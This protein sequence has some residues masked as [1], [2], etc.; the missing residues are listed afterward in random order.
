MKYPLLIAMLI[1]LLPGAGPGRA[2]PEATQETTD[3]YELLLVKSPQPGA[4]FDRVVEWYSTQGGGLEL[5]QKRW[6]DAAA[7]DAAQ[8][9]QY[10]ILQGLLAERLRRT[11]KARALYGEAL[12]GGGDVAGAARLLAALET[13]EGNFPA[14]AEA[15]NMALAAET[16]PPMDRLDVMRSLALMYQRSFEDGKALAVWRQAME[17]FPDDPYVLEEAGEAFLAAEEYQ[18]ARETFTRLRD[19]SKKDPF[20]RIAASLRLARTADLEGRKDDAVHIYDL[21]LEETSEGSWINREIRGRIE[22]IYRRKDD[23]PGLLAYY[24]KRTVA[25]PQDYQSLVAQAQVLD[26]LGRDGEATERY[27]AAIKLAP[28]DVGLRLA[29]IGRLGSGGQEGEAMAEA[30]ELAKPADAPVE[31]LEMAGNLAWKQ[32]ETAKN[33]KSRELALAYWQRIAPAEGRDTAR[34]AR[35]AE[36]LSSHGETDAAV[37]Q[38]QRLLAVA[39]DATDARQRLAEVYQK[40]GDKAAALAVLEAMAGGG[41]SQPEN[42]LALARIEQRLEWKDEARATLKQARQLF[43]GNYDILNLSWNQ[44]LEDGDAA[45]AAELFSPVLESAPNAFFAGDVVKKYA[46]FLDRDGKGKEQAARLAESLTRAVDAEVLLRLALAQQ[47]RELAEKAVVFLKGQPNALQAAQAGAE[48]AQVFGTTEE[49][50][51]ALQAVAAADPR[52]AGDSLRAMARIQ[53]EAGETD[54]ALQTISQL[55]E[56]TPVDGS[57]YTLYADVASRD[58]RNDAAIARLR[59]GSRFVK[60]ATSLRLQLASLLQGQGRM[61]EAARTLQEAFEKED[62]DT[63]RKDIFRQQ[64]ACAMAMGRLDDLVASLREKQ[65]KEQGGARY[66]AYL[67]E[68]FILQNDFLAAGEELSRSLGRNPDN[69]DAV[70]RLLD[71]ADRGGD[72]QEGLRLAKRLVEIEPN[73]ENRASYLAR[74]FRAGEVD[75]GRAEFATVRAEIVK[76]PEGWDEVLSAMQD[77]GLKAETAAVAEEMAGQPGAGAA[78]QVQLAR[79]R[80]MQRDLKGA[81]AR[82]WQVVDVEDFGKG[83]GQALAAQPATPVYPGQ[84]AVWQRWKPVS[85]IANSTRNDLQQY[86]QPYYRGRMS[87][88]AMMS[89]AYWPGG[90][91]AMSGA[92]L[93]PD[94]RARLEAYFLLAMIAQAEGRGDDFSRRM[95]E[96]FA[97]AGVPGEIQISLLST[98]QNQDG[99]K[100]LILRQAENGEGDIEADRVILSF[101]GQW[102]D[103]DINAAMDRISDRVAK[104]NPRDVLQY[105]YGKLAKELAELYQGGKEND[106]K[107]QAEARERIRRFTESPGFAED[108]TLRLQIA[109]NAVRAGDM[110]LADKLLAETGAAGDGTAQA[111][112]W[113][114]QVRNVRMQI[115]LQ[116][117]AAN[118]PKAE[119]DLEKLLADMA[120]SPAPGMVMFSRGMAFY[121]MSYGMGRHGGGGMLAQQNSELVVGDSEFPVAVFSGLWQMATASQ[122]D[123]VE[124]WFAARAKPEMSRD[125]VGA[126]YAEWFNNGR[127]RALKRLE[128]VHGKAPTPRS[129]ALLL[130]AC[131]RMSKQAEALGVIDLAEM[132]ANETVSVRKLRKLRLLREAGRAEEARKLAEEMMKG[133]VPSDIRDPLI[134]ELSQLGIPATKLQAGRMMYRS[135]NTMDREN[136]IRQQVSKL[137]NEKKTDEAERIALHI[138]Q[139][140]LPRGEDYAQVSLR[141]S[142]V[143]S[144]SSMKRL[145]VLQEPLRER[146]VKDPADADAA[147][148]LAESSRSGDFTPELDNMVKIVAANPERVSQIS[149]ALALLSDRGE[150]RDRGMEL[151]CEILRTNPGVLVSSGMDL[152]QQVGNRSN[153]PEAAAL[154]A[155]TVAG[156][157][158]E[159]YAMV[160]LPARLGGYTSELPMIGQLAE[161]AMQAGKPAQAVALLKRALKGSFLGVQMQMEMYVPAV[162][163]LAEL[164]LAKGD[165]EGAAET[166]KG[167]LDVPANARRGGLAMAIVNLLGNYNPG[168]TG[169]DQLNRMA[170]LA[171]KTGTLETM[172]KALDEEQKGAPGVSASLLLRTTLGRPEV[173]KEWRR[174]AKSDNAQFQSVSLPLFGAIIRMLADQDDADVLIPAILDKLPAQQVFYGGDYSLGYLAAALPVLAKYRENPAVRKHVELILNQSMQGPNLQYLPHSQNYMMCLNALLDQGYVAEAKKLYDATASGRAARNFGN[175]QYFQQIEVR[176]NAAEKKAGDISVVCAAMESGPEKM[177]VAWRMGWAT[178]REDDNDRGAAATWSEMREE[179]PESVHPVEMEILAG[180]NP[181]A[182]EKIATVSKPDVSGSVEGRAPA[183]LGMLQA[184]WK[185]RQGEV[186]W[187]PLTAY[188]MGGNLVVKNG[189]PMPDGKP[190]AGF[191]ANLPGPLGKGTASGFKLLSMQ[192]QYTLPLAA[193]R[194]ADGDANALVVAGW[195]RG[196]QNGATPPMLQIRGERKGAQAY[197][198]TLY[199]RQMSG[200]WRQTVGVWT[201]NKQQSPYWNLGDNVESLE[202]SLLFQAYNGYNMQMLIEGQWASLQVVKLKLPDNEETA[203]SLLSKARMAMQKAG[204]VKEKYS[205]AADIYLQALRN[206]PEY[207]LNQWSSMLETFQKAGRMPELFTVLSNPALYLANPLRNYQRTVQNDSLI[208]AMVKA[209]TLPDAPEAAKVWL[210]GVRSAPLSDNQRYLIEACLLREKAKNDPGSVTAKDVLRVMGYGEGDAVDRER[211]S[212]L[213]NWSQES[214]AGQSLLELVT[215]RQWEPELAAQLKGMHPPIESVFSHNMLQAWVLAPLDPAAALEAWKR[216]AALRQSGQSY[217]Y[218]NDNV[219]EALFARLAGSHPSPGDLVAAARV[220]LADG[221]N[222]DYQQRRLADMLYAASKDKGPRSGEYAALW[223]DQEIAS[224]QS[225]DY[226][227]QRE[228]I[229]ELARRLMEEGNWPRLEKLLGLAET[230]SSLKSSDLQR[231]FAQLRDLA[232]LSQ[233]NVDR[234]WP[235]AWCKPGTNAR[236]VAACWQWN[237]RDA[238]PSEGRVDV[239]VAVAD[240]PPVPQIKGQTRVEMEFGVM[241]SGMVKVGEAEGD[242]A[243]GAM[244]I[245]L[246]AD[247]GFLRAVAVIGDRRVPGPLTPVISGK[248][249]FPAPGASLQDMLA[250]GEKPLS[251][252]DLAEAGTAPD[253]SP[254]LRIGKTGNGNNL[255]YGGPDFLVTPGKFYVGRIWIKRSGRGA[256]TS[257]AQ[258]RA[259]AGAQWGGLNMILSER[260][261]TTGQWV[262]YTRAVPTLPQHTFWIPYQKVEAVIP[263]L[264]DVS[265]GTEIAGFELIEIEGWKY[266]QWIS[267]LALLRDGA[268]ETPDAATVDKAL[269]LAVTEPLTSL[270][271]HGDWLVQRA[272]AQKQTDRVLDLYRSAFAAE[273]NPLFARPKLN[274]VFSSLM[275]LADAP[276]APMEA[277]LAAVKLAQENAERARAPQRFAFLRR[278]L[279]LVPGAETSAKIRNDLMARFKDEAKGS[280]FLRSTLTAR[281]YTDDRPVNEFL[282]LQ[283]AWKDPEMTG[284]ILTQL[285]DPRGKGMSEHECTF[286]ALALEACLAPPGP[287][288]KERI[289][290]GFER[291]RSDSVEMAMYWPSLLGE[292]LA[293]QNQSPDVLMHLRKSGFERAKVR[294]VNSYSER[295]EMIRAAGYLLETGIAQN[296][297]ATTKETADALMEMLKSNKSRLNDSMLR[298]LLRSVIALDDGGQKESAAEIIRIVEKDVRASSKMKDAYAKYLPPESGPAAAPKGARRE[299]E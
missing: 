174:L 234:A 252:A 260:S 281:V 50:I 289:T 211:L 135:R 198:T 205:E 42:Y 132:Q 99:L 235:V 109:G 276:E 21:A 128:E 243:D 223:A 138:L 216:A 240:K 222:A 140:P 26:D 175:N 102:N 172:L 275:K 86:F 162:L 218:L 230:K 139:Q 197:D 258:Y 58:G 91:P 272:V 217:G 297:A 117:I 36:I 254:A 33:A 48:M 64:I 85:D 69:A 143:D 158:D 259:A 248:R 94:L 229:R 8:K 233:G 227:P 95:E 178:G 3:R 13:T 87:R 110:E 11:D 56:R 265:P 98:S 10:L 288:A 169:A 17:K 160:F 267:D 19:I 93:S 32:Y 51:A 83:L 176:L 224:L 299:S 273:T 163:R 171:E 6:E 16:L 120:G 104:T 226:S 101:G 131:E 96:I 61:P 195:V 241:P 184:R 53:A 255:A 154:L 179:L 225:P 280:D 52:M 251:M 194:T 9:R 39:P 82:L 245:E 27:R 15:Y 203:S 71:L 253:G 57:L 249:V 105:R 78:V 12:K 204:D 134:A 72:E 166:M 168:V 89:S 159:T 115:V 285:N 291:S 73:K 41:N 150:K 40:K 47:N 124:K 45:L 213:W 219:A 238:T 116:E 103:A 92:A 145:H 34:I 188:V 221:N 113:Q 114:A 121:P 295:L 46:S 236:K 22:E 246:P 261:E 270:D 43:P 126:F 215:E 81:Q 165:R 31:A 264:W 55:I 144:L 232:S 23:L 214:A 290:K 271:Y 156:L 199:L 28:S 220:L 228:R 173:A 206:N 294:N 237:I 125:T 129:A 77:A 130:E 257:S 250:A 277:R 177:K 292:M 70:S 196:A 68:I 164:Q 97:K 2:E 136:Q 239:A 60:D 141:R 207:T 287:D 75:A 30:A 185:T 262:L 186:R 106:P 84:P 151:I 263:R 231:E 24:E 293:A 149:Y 183:P 74:L 208:N 191:T 147:I 146:L 37:A 187:G 269:Q 4:A 182:M 148:R 18:S 59:E 155:E 35:L 296:D 247:N 5:L 209:A 62:N 180:P 88:R 112:Y 38:W 79:M 118:D 65:A 54:A 119:Q 76:D 25:V 1:L 268:G 212:L 256:V 242:K 282:S 284:F 286:A 100:R 123:A 181:A 90:A 108:A 283:A 127:E 200:D 201:W 244:E 29:F 44:A 7:G 142:M 161:A 67:A 279:A 193:C 80:L 192:S 298:V 66:G 157:N 137:I 189:V 152:M 122:K 153:S 14:A 167:L 133:R 274:R 111:A 210:A 266:G 278:E 170:S 202:V 107:V 190:A 49:Q 63:R 20:R